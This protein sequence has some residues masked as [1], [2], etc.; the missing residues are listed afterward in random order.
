MS[1]GTA[2]GAR[3]RVAA[4]TV[5]VFDQARVTVRPGTDV[6]ARLPGVLF[7]AHA[8]DDEAE[9][10]LTAVLELLE[11]STVRASRAPGYRVTRALRE[12]VESG[13]G[14]PDLAALAATDDRLAV[15]LCGR[16]RIAALDGGWHLSCESGELLTRE[17]DWP[18]TA[19]LL[20]VGVDA[21]DG[22]ESERSTARQRAFDLRSGVVPGGG[23]VLYPQV[24]AMTATGTFPVRAD[25]L[26]APPP[27]LHPGSAPSSVPPMPDPPRRCDAIRG[28]SPVGR[29]RQPLPVAQSARSSEDPADESVGSPGAEV[30]GFRCRDGH[31]NDPRVYF[32]SICGIR[33]AESTGVFVT[34]PRPS[35]GLLVF[36]NGASF[37]LDADYLLGREPDIDERVRTGQ[38]RPLVVFDTTGVVSRRHAEIRLVDWDV[39]IV[40]C[41][42][43]NGTL[44][45]ERD[46]ADWSALVPGQAIPMPPGMTVRVGERSFVFES[47]LRA[48]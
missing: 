21:P 17:M 32:C 3:P 19:V 27:R 16:G 44:V 8:A 35:L 7:A 6:V 14:L 12:L 11:A 30:R 48:T 43:S 40:D 37:S 33:M 42:S 25:L 9:A 28:I 5:P 2:P 23:A 22:T 15:V 4:S 10:G 47:A 20:Q 18:H 1:E 24:A 26:P 41:G 34:G 45:A 31:L 13:A 38:L 39:L 36:D 29:P 46:A